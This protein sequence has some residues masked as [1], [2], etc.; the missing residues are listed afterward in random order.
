MP[1]D[2]KSWQKAADA[3]IADDKAK[4]QAYTELPLDVEALDSWSEMAKVLAVCR[5]GAMDVGTYLVIQRK[6]REATQTVFTEGVHAG[7]LLARNG[8]D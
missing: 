2:E 8:E 1:F 5:A 6:L 7:Y 4:A 3:V